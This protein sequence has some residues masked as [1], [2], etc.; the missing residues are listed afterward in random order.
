MHTIYIRIDEDLGEYDMGAVRDNLR[1]I[2]HVTD[3]EMDAGSS[4]NMLIEFEEEHVSPIAILRQLQRH[5]IHADIMS[6]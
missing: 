4:H 3:V 5:G 2:G 6:G 1:S